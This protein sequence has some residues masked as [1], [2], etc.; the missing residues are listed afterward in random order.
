[1]FQEKMKL[2]KESAVFPANLRSR[3]LEPEAESPLTKATPAV[4][5]GTVRMHAPKNKQLVQLR[6]PSAYPALEASSSRPHRFRP[7]PGIEIVPL[8]RF[9][10]V[11]GEAPEG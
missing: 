8:R 3:L 10:W 5:A 9:K 1:M 2:L 6:S 7:S 4:C 11:T